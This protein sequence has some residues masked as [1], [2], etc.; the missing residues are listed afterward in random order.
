MK[1]GSIECVEVVDNSVS[2][3]PHIKW[4]IR[5]NLGKVNTLT[6]EE[7]DT[8]TYTLTVH[9]INHP[10][11]L[12]LYWD[13]GD[14]NFGIKI[15]DELQ[16]AIVEY[17]LPTGAAIEEDQSVITLDFADPSEDEGVHYKKLF[18]DMTQMDIFRRNLENELL[19]KVVQF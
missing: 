6:I 7:L 10:R 11:F 4:K 13:T 9:I 16:E 5:T 19:F 3:P 8:L 17:S 1:I 2:E 15:T 12:F 18:L 14:D